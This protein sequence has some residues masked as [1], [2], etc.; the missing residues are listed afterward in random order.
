[1]KK[2]LKI[3]G[4]AHLVMAAAAA[5]AAQCLRHAVVRYSAAHYPSVSFNKNQL[6]SGS[7]L[8]VVFFLHMRARALARVCALAQMFCMC[9]TVFIPHHSSATSVVLRWIHF[10]I[11]PLEAS[12]A[13]WQAEAFAFAAPTW[14]LTEA[15]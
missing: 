4:K 11:S 8:D 6:P 13:G 5:S 3:L 2:N 10:L 1:M 12:L 14:M 9:I 7:K 15:K